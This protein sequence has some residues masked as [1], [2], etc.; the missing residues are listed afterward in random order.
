[1]SP[2]VAVTMV[3]DG[4]G[5][6]VNIGNGPGLQITGALTISCWV[7]L[8]STP[9]DISFVSKYKS[10]SYGFQLGT[11]ED[12]SETFAIFTIGKTKTTGMGSGWAAWPSGLAVGTRHHLA[13][14]FIPSTAVQ[15]WQDGALTENTTGVPATQYD[16]S[17]DVF[18]GARF[19]GQNFDGAM[20]DVRIYNR[21]LTSDEILEIRRSNGADK[22]FRGLVYRALLREKASGQ[23]ADGAAGAIKD[24][25][26]NAY[27]GTIVGN[28][29][30]GEIRTQLGVGA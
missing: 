23:N 3:F 5:D 30:Y 25:G 8:G 20:E 11:D 26:P 6:K 14:V 27:H 7:I 12:G 16:P 18:V 9:Q 4:T 29:T 13:G 2:G 22:N 19:S 10:G 17:Q 21:A 24:V 15:V 1:M 28:P